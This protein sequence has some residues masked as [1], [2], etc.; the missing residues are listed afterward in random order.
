MMLVSSARWCLWSRSEAKTNIRP[1]EACGRQTEM[2]SSSSRMT[3][4]LYGAGAVVRAAVR[5]CRQNA[6][7]VGVF[8]GAVVVFLLANRRYVASLPHQAGPTAR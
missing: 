6:A 8:A 4:W 1:N 2:N 7:S 3:R 5:A